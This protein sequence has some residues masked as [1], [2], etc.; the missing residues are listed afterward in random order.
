MPFKDRVSETFIRAHV[1]RLP[2]QVVARYGIQTD[3]VDA[4]GRKI[5]WW[6]WW[7]REAARRLAP[8]MNSAGSAFF[9][10][11][12]LKSIKADAVLAEYGTTGDW[13][14]SAC[15]KAG[16]P[17]FVHFH[18]YDAWKTDLLEIHRTSYRR[19]FETAAGVVAVSEPM[20]EQL[21]RLGAKPERLHLSLYG[22]DPECFDGALPGQQ[23]PRF[24]AVGRFVEKKAPYLTLLAFS[25]V[26]PFVSDATLTMV[27]DGPLLGPCKRLA[28][29][30]G[31]VQSV[32]F[33][34]AQTSDE[35]GR[36]MRDARA[37]VQHSLKAEDGDCEGTPVGIIEAQM[38]GLPVVSTRHAGIP[39]VVVEGGTGFLVEEGDAQGMAAAMRRLAESPALAGTLGKA[40]RDRALAN[41]TLDRHL[42]DLT[43]MI[44]AELPISVVHPSVGV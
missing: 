42:A 13:L 41:F 16:V 21:L 6:G 22:V 26:I 43:R 33:A 7:F 44:E 36:L 11:W 28:A 30:L 40:A 4:E 14:A 18:G 31:L 3:L 37:F 35:V 25:Q 15:V 29:A 23:P 39:H 8:K 12:H 19:M 17:L 24:V 27:G 38:S 5:W 2:F 20:R 1:E 34:G 9:L 10:A 32:T